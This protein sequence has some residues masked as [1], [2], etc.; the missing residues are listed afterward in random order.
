MLPTLS[1]GWSPGSGRV[2]PGRASPRP[3][4]VQG[5]GGA[6]RRPQ[7]SVR[8][9]RT[10]VLASAGTEGRTPWREVGTSREH[11]SLRKAGEGAD[12]H[13]ASRHPSCQQEAAPSTVMLSLSDPSGR[14]RDRQILL[15]P[16]RPPGPASTGACGP[17]AVYTWAFLPSF[18]ALKFS[19][20]WV[21]K[22]CLQAKATLQPSVIGVLMV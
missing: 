18:P 22:K 2:P 15:T 7:R 9:G 8:A 4:S 10:A 5:S 12:I 16:T 21:C 20:K 11:P 13:P 17:R 3:P 6:R 1:C 19:R 14:D